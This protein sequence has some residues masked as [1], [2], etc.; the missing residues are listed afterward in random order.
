MRKSLKF[1]EG[2]IPYLIMKMSFPMILASLITQ[3]VQ[4]TNMAF[5]GN[6]GDDEAYLRSLYIPFAFL[7]IALTEGIQISNQ[8]SVS[9]LKGERKYEEIRLN[10][11]NFIILG[12]GISL[13]VLL[14]VTIFGPMLISLFQIPDHLEKRF[15]HFIYLMFLASTFSVFLL[16][17]IS[18]LRGIGK[19]NL[20]SSL[21]ISYA[22]VNVGLVYYFSFVLKKGLF[23]IFFGNILSALVLI[24]VTLTY[25]IRSKLIIFN[26]KYFKFYRKSLHY[27]KVVG[28]PISLSYIVIFVSSFFFNLIIKPFGPEAISGFG[29]AYYIQT[30]SIVPSIAIGTALGII[31]NHNIG[32]GNQYY[33]RVYNTYKT[34]SIF[35]I[36][37]YLVISTM[38]FL[39]REE[40]V[41]L[42][43]KNE[44]S[45]NEATLYLFIVTPSYV[46]MGLSL[47]TITTLEQINKGVIAVL[48]NI[49]YFVMII[50][51]GWF[52]TTYFGESNYLYWTMSLTNGLGMIF[53]V[54][55]GYLIRK[56]F[57]SEVKVKRETSLI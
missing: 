39:F 43:I 55:M 18:S 8:V 4:L 13:I 26:R 40:I 21:I 7:I 51:V 17:L 16:I 35:T 53:V 47:M 29:V 12:I 24:V 9:R 31:M 56:E 52:L 34:G 38:L 20:A 37:F 6:V 33:P 57:L 5:M 32:A 42:M 27:I 11:N 44:A 10:I 19:V 14:F 23:S 30:F 54:S 25:L 28:I 36:L 22:A 41:S 46:F 49:L 3:I 1:L 48:F 2:K 15:M 50:G 45:I